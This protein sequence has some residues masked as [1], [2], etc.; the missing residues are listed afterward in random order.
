MSALSNF[1]TGPMGP[2]THIFAITPHDTNALPATCKAIRAD[3]AGA[4]TFRTIDSA[5]N[6]T[7]TLAAGEYV[8]AIITHVRDT[9]TDA[10][11]IHGFA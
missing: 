2:A 3:A 7:L 6:V 1:R 4:V 11:V 5:A 9:G 8:S 10:I